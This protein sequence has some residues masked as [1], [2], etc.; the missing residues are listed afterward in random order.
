VVCSVEGP[1][2]DFREEVGRYFV[3][4]CKDWARPADFSA[5]AKF[6]RVLDSVKARF[7]IIFS[8]EGITG[9]SGVTDA[10]LEQIKVF[11][12]RGLVIVVVDLSNLEA[13]A[14]GVNFVSLLRQKYEQVRLELR[15]A[16][17]MPA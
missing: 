10:R 7:G 1:A 9:E 15:D 2:V 16:A 13:L 12:D 11:Q 17:P 6:C 5:F 8:R 3:C 4:E 14:H